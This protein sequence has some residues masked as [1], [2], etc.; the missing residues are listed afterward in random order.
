MPAPDELTSWAREMGAAYDD[1]ALILL[2]ER[3]AGPRAPGAGVAICFVMR[4]GSQV[5]WFAEGKGLD[6]LAYAAV[7]GR[8]VYERILADARVQQPGLRLY[9]NFCDSRALMFAYDTGHERLAGDEL[10][11]R[12]RILYPERD[13]VPP[14]E[15]FFYL[16]GDAL[17]DDA[18]EG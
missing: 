16:W 4:D 12:F 18:G 2:V 3:G 10:R 13:R 14:L 5:P 17:A 11:G 8:A 6:G 7:P 1:V 9:L 15:E